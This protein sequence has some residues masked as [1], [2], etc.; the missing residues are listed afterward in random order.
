MRKIPYNKSSLSKQR[1]LD[2]LYRK[3]LPSLDLKRRQLTA[4]LNKARAEHKARHG[5]LDAF[6]PRVAAELPMLANRQIALDDLLHLS[7]V[8]VDEENILGAKVPVFRAVR[9]REEPYSFLAKPHWVDA[10][11]ARMREAAELI[12]RTEIAGQRV[13]RLALALKRVTQRVNLFE[14]VLIPR[15]AENIRKIEIF[16]ADAERSAVVRSKIF[17]ERQRALAAERRA[18]FI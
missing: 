10:F 1:G 16:L 15:T 8:V 13:E 2:K 14:K 3:L 18:A 7:E 4:E 9:T 12:A 5:E 6:A 17:K 11:V